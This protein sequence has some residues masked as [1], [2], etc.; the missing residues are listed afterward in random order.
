MNGTP[1]GGH[2]GGMTSR[3]P[4]PPGLRRTAF[5]TSDP[6]SGLGRGRLRGDGVAHPFHGVSAIDLDP[7]DV[8]DRVHAFAPNLLPGQV[9]SHT[10][11]LSL[12][13]AALPRLP[14][15]LHVTVRFPR[16]PPR[17][18]G[19]TGHSLGEAPALLLD[20]LPVAPPE[21]AWAQA[22]A[23]LGVEDLVAAGDAL[24]TGAR[25]RGARAG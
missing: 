16:T 5:R 24:V 11:A 2:G 19:I 1:D 14:A 18:R 20:G 6:A 3:I 8:R 15:D 23:L 10:T 12:H 21:V 4:I 17:G 9:Y 13:G 25:M 7:G 22:G